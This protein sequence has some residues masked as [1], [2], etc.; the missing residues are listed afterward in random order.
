MTARSQKR[1]VQV[2]RVG[3]GEIEDD[4]ARLHE[5]RAAEA[6]GERGRTSRKRASAAVSFSM[7]SPT[8]SG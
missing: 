5:D 3:D 7:R 1:H 2:Q 6:A 8:H 4:D